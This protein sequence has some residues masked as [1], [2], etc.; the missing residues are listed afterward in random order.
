VKRRAAAGVLLAALLAAAPSARAEAPRLSPDEVKTRWAE[1][2]AGL[3]FVA[4]VTL[5]YQMPGSTET[6]LLSV[7][8]DDSARLERVMARFEAPPPMR[9]FGLLYLQQSG[10]PND[11][12]VY[13]PEIGRVRRIAETT[14]SQDIY[15]VDLEFLGFGVAQSQP[16]EPES[17]RIEKLDGREVYRLEER[18]RAPQ[19]RFDRRIAYLDAE[20]FVPL[21]VEQHREGELA[22]V[23]TT[24]EWRLVQ[25]VPTPMLTRFRRPKEGSE[26]TLV[27]ES[28]DY[29]APIPG[30]FFST[31]ALIKK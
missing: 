28:I 5:H 16:T 2:L 8:R 25:G 6:R 10:R 20:T 1:R 23:A 22:L 13:Q 17:V 30:I 31:L 18:S 11:Y 7:W 19:Q 4:S 24:E 27:V 12:F 29:A 9:G 15:G 26:V 14:A 21:R 3:H